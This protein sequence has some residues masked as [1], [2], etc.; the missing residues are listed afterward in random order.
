MG[1]L[2]SGPQRLLSADRRR[3]LAAVLPPPDSD[4]V[5]RLSTDGT[6]AV[7]RSHGVD[8][9]GWF[10]ASSPMAAL[11]AWVAS[12]GSVVAWDGTDGGKGGGGGGGNAGGGG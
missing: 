3:F 5:S 6:A 8:A 10:A 1:V 4:Q 9:S 2:G 11:S 12:A 7:S